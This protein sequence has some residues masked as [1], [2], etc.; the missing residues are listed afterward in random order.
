MAKSDAGGDYSQSKA[1]RAAGE[2]AAVAALDPAADADWAMKGVALKYLCLGTHGIYELRGTIYLN[3][4][5][6]YS[7]DG[8]G[9]SQPV[10]IEAPAG[11]KPDLSAVTEEPAG[12]SPQPTQQPFLVGSWQRRT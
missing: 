12:G 2:A 4:G 11:L 3:T 7:S 5:S 9:E 10:V 6:V 1:A 8:V